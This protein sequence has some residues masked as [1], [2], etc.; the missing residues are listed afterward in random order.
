MMRGAARAAD[1]P[2]SVKPG[3]VGRIW[4]FARPFRAL[5][6][7]FI[8]LTVVTATIG[9]VTPILAGS[10]VNAIVG[11]GAAAAGTVVWLA[12]GIAALAITEALVGLGNRWFSA[13]IGEGLIMHLR[14]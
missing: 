2:A 6:A 3:T 14:S 8:T 12:S 13:R 9:V 4:R 5:F 11:G 7:G 1:A 10:V